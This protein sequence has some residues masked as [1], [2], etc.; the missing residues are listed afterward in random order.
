MDEKYKQSYKLWE[1][2][3]CRIL[4]L[5]N[6]DA[7][8]EKEFYMYEYY[9]FID[10]AYQDKLI[11]ESV[12]KI[13]TD[14][15]ELERLCAEAYLRQRAWKWDDKHYSSRISQLDKKAATL[16]PSKDKNI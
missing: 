13:M 3:F 6:T 4:K 2:Q 15:N 11:K 16:M 1:N 10:T 7:S 9:K 5:Y 14:D 12:Q 8:I